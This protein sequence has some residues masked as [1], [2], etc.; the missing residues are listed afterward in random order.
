M[1]SISIQTVSTNEGEKTRLLVMVYALGYE[2]LIDSVKEYLAELV[3]EYDGNS[4]ISV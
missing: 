3:Y 2:G 4:N 1:E